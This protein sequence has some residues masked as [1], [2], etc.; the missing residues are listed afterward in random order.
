LL[1]GILL[2]NYVN[3]IFKEEPTMLELNDDFVDSVLKFIVVPQTSIEI[4]CKS[5]RLARLDLMS[6]DPRLK[7]LQRRQ[8]GMRFGFPFSSAFI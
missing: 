7:N 2:L 6:K 4:G 3:D 5:T 1:E 8:P